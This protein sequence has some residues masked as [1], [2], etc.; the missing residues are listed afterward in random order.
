MTLS[1]GRAVNCKPAAPLPR[2][3]RAAACVTATGLSCTETMVVRGLTVLLRKLALTFTLPLP[4]P[5]A[6]DATAKLLFPGN[7][8]QAQP[9]P[10]VTSIVA[11]P[12][13][14]GSDMV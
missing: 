5:V 10:A 6:G 7:A 9:S 1:P 13:K 3:V 4:R 12:P 2:A 11:S 8:D 14:A